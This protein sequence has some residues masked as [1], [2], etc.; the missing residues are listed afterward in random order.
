MKC[1][2]LLPPDETVAATNG[3]VPTRAW[4]AL[5]AAALVLAVAATLGWFDLRQ[6]SHAAQQREDELKRR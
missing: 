1:L 2:N 4:V 5:S 3:G 6:R